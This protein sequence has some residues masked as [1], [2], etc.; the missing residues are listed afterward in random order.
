MLLNVF[1]K[2]ETYE[3]KKDF[4]LGTNLLNVNRVVSALA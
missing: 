3:Y 1:A 2:Q 4:I